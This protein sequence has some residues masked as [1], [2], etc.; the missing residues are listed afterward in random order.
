M[1]ARPILFFRNED[2]NVFADLTDDYGFQNYM[3]VSA[4]T[5]VDFDRDGDLD[6]ITNPFIS[7]F[8]TTRT[9]RPPP[10]YIDG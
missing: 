10:V 9:L 7:L 4:Y 3:I 5:V 6:F 2:G 1:L 8:L